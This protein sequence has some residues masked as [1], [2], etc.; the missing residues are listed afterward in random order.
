VIALLTVLIVLVALQSLL[1]VGLLRAYGAV[2][3]RLHQLDGGQAAVG[4]PPFRVVP[5][6]AA[7][8]APP[9]SPASASAGVPVD[10]RDEWRAGAD[11]TGATPAGE[12]V[13][14][15]VV[16]V[17]HDTVLAFLSTTCAG[18]EGFWAQLAGAEAWRPGA[19]AR[20]VVVAK[21]AGEDRNA[22]ALLAGAADLVLS[23]QAWE[24]Y[25]VP[26]SPYVVV[27]DGR[28]GRVKGEGSGTSF[29]QMSA[30]IEQAAG[31]S[32][33]AFGRGRPDGDLRREL[34]VDRALLAAGITPGHPSL[35][36]PDA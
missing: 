17:A 13:S 5:E 28:T 34:D 35:Y 20:L 31:D 24:D 7:P 19:G 6:I 10:G 36:G 32:R 18:C 29:R 3:R 8:S 25:A 2:L 16:G 26:G 27:V 14:L 23:D 21:D 12:V 4:A 30:L 33:R 11:L 22:L 15:R 1:L 9:A